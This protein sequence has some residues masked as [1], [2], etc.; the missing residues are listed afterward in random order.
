MKCAK[1]VARMISFVW[2]TAL[3]A[4][5]ATA[6]VPQATQSLVLQSDRLALVF[7]RKTG[8]L[9]ALQNKLTGE[10]YQVQGD[11][12]EIEAT[13]FRVGFADA[14]LVSLDLQAN[15]LKVT[16]RAG[17]LSIEVRYALRGRFVE[18]YI[19]ITSRRDYALKTSVVSGPAFSAAD[20]KIVA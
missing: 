7:D 17:E 4:T 1:F 13:Q 12:F 18:K 2:F 20:L 9:T 16:Y 10:T 8:T 19:T 11:R 3:L 5:A 15:T 14:K 6:D